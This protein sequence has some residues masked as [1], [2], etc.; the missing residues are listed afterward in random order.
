MRVSFQE[1][2]LPPGKI[3]GQVVRGVSIERKSSSNWRRAFYRKGVRQKP[4]SVAK[5]DVSGRT[6]A[7]PPHIT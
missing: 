4:K 3:A 1:T 5:F 6:I 7:R 2:V